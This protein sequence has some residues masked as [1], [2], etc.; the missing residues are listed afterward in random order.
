MSKCWLQVHAPIYKLV[1]TNLGG[2]KRFAGE[3]LGILRS[4]TSFGLIL[5]AFS[6]MSIDPAAY[7][8]LMNGQGCAKA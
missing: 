8:V 5:H 3:R 6:S 2:E 7:A 1:F 4:Q